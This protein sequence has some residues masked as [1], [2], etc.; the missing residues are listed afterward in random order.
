[1]LVSYARGMTPTY[2]RPAIAE[3]EY[4]DALG[5]TVAYGRQRDRT[6]EQGPRHA[7]TNVFSHQERYLPIFTV[8]DALI[9]HLAASYDVVVD[10]DI[11]QSSRFDIFRQRP[12]ATFARVVGIRPIEPTEA[13]L[14]IGFHDYPGSMRVLAGWY[15][16]FD[17]WFCGCDACDE[18][19]EDVADSLE[20]V[21]LTVVDRGTT[22]RLDRRRR[23]RAR[24][25]LDPS[26]RSAWAGSIP[27][28]EMRPQLLEAVSSWYRKHEDGRWMPWTPRTSKV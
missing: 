9:S 5:R 23:G 25:W 7:E 19:W 2:S 3:R 26:R 1:M 16:E 21:I 14:V 18:P 13:P 6:P 22:E 17:M 28:Q 27:K 12:D 10:D 4:V 15:S 8:A 11:R 20:D 24:Y